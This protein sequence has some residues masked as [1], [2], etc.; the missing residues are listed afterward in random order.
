VV[1]SKTGRIRPKNGRKKQQGVT[2]LYSTL[3]FFCTSYARDM[4]FNTFFFVIFITFYGAKIISGILVKK[5]KKKSLE[6]DLRY[7]NRCI[8]DAQKHP[9]TDVTLRSLMWGNPNCIISICYSELHCVCG[10]EI[11]AG[12]YLKLLVLFALFVLSDVPDRVDFRAVV[13]PRTG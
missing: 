2:T 13:S 8:D 3:S 11:I 5:K 4:H 10:D 1:R 12:V 6:L 9:S 7:Y